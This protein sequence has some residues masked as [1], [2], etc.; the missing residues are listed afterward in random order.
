[1]PNP[2]LASELRAAADAL[3]RFESK[4]EGPDVEPDLLRRAADAL[5]AMRWVRCGDGL[6]YRDQ[7][8]L[9]LIECSGVQ[10]IRT[11]YLH[12]DSD[13]FYM[14]GVGRMRSRV[15]PTHWMPL[16]PAPEADPS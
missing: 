3:D 2:A 11:G 9:L 4:R 6:P 12:P 13:N 8:V 16:P 1:M 10:A 5:D 7:V 14:T 15:I